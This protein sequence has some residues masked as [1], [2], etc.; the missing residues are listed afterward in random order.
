MSKSEL[1]R[2][3]TRT[4]Q[5]LPADARQ[6]RNNAGGFSFEVDDVQRL[7]RFL[8]LG[9]E[10]GT[11]YVQ[12]RDLALD[13]ANAVMRLAQSD[14]T[15]L[16]N[17]IVEVSEAGRA[18]RQQP[19]LFALAIAA[20]LSDD[21]GRAYALDVMPRVARTGT[22]LFEFL[23]YA[24]QFRGWGRGLRRAVR[25][26]YSEKTVEQAAYQAV[27]YR[28]RAGWTHRDALRLAHPNVDG[29]LNLLFRWI[30]SWSRDDG[31]GR[32]DRVFFSGSDPLAVV[33]AYER[34]QRTN[35]VADAVGIV[36]NSALSWEMLPDHLLNEASVWEALLDK[37]LPV[38]ALVRQLP[39]LT[40]LGLLSGSANWTSRV[41]ATLTD[42]DALRRGRVH[43]FNLLVAARTYASGGGYR[44][45]SSWQPVPEVTRALETG[46]YRAFRGV[47][48]TGKR[49]MLALDVSG[50]MGASILNSPL[51]CRE[52]SAALALVTANV[53]E[54]YR[55]M[56]FTHDL[57]PLHINPTMNLTQA[58]RVVSSLPFGGTDCGLP[59][60]HARRH[61]L[62]VD[63]FVVY[64]DNET[65][66][67][68]G[69]PHE[70]LR[71]YR[72]VTGIDARLVVVGM[73]STGFSIADPSDAG[74][75]DVVGFDSATPE[76]I[77]AFA[78][79]EV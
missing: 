65:W 1:T 62:E 13:N 56:G 59:M 69:H 4:E 19:G 41:R 20:S 12:P 74:M 32:N 35:S 34:V 43:P 3:T 29:D 76:L 39:R 58:V 63:T 53:E 17:T 57:V 33:E 23:T 8:V 54:D 66:Y 6:R 45:S 36:A 68:V 46:F 77:S 15:T 30:T 25:R 48:P 37:G 75:L 79:G 52:A 51:S 78:R 5:T 44:S 40:R 22:T 60:R 38:T 42:P 71:L 55:L 7:R 31:W 72:E 18:P 50:S 16:V 61:H 2:I 9:V 67:G 21:E 73:T 28:Q 27:K 11:F 70:E 14:P 49:V 10:G 26:W 24:Q 47:E 64:T